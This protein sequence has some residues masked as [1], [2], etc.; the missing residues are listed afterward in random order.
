MLPE[1]SKITEE[2]GLGT[3][4]VPREF[5]HTLVSLLSSDGML[6]EDIAD[7]VGYKGMVTTAAATVAHSTPRRSEVTFRRPCSR[8]FRK[9]IVPIGSP[10]IRWPEISSIPASGRCLAIA[11]VP[12]WLIARAVAS[13]GSR[14]L[15]RVLGC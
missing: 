10:R 4:W 6:L 15:R 2:A 1:F 11:S 7:L 5:R 12:A 9:R 3:D 13:S 8:G 14:L